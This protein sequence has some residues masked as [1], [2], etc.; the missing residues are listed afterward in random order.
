MSNWSKILTR[1][2][3]EAHLMAHLEL[4]PVTIPQECKW[5]LGRDAVQL[6]VERAAAWRCNDGERYMI[7]QSLLA[8]VGA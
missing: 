4:D 1:A 7:A 6:R 2:Q 3:V 8:S 5:W